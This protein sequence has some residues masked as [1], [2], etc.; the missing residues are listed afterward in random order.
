MPVNQA[1]LLL[2]H[3]S[4][5]PVARAEY[6]NV[7][8]EVSLRLPGHR[9]EF[10]VLEFPGDD[11]KSIADGV[12][13]CV[14]AGAER[15]IALPYFLFVAGHVGED[16]PG[17]LAAAAAGYPELTLAYQPPLGVDPAVVEVLADRVNGVLPQPPADDGAAVVL[18][19]A[20]TSDPLANADL[21]RAARLLWERRRSEPVEVAFVSLTEPRLD[22]VVR[23][24][25]VLGAR[26]LVVV[27]Y[28]LNTGVLSRR[29]ETQLADCRQQYQPLETTLTPEMGLHPRL[30]DLLAERARAALAAPRT[31]LALPPCSGGGAWACWLSPSNQ[32][33]EA[34]LGV[35]TNQ[36]I[37]YDLHNRRP[38]S[39][40]G[41]R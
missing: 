30:L 11:L 17:E 38:G 4:R 7:V 14:E 16:L 35:T 39:S 23:R 9:V 28:F 25:I 8:R 22:E 20:G 18:V 32:E 36:A 13:A 21:Y 26:R 27:P 2:A 10:S 15:V 31:G 37:A 40:G 12:R 19:G 3:G 34:P 5:N 6:G 1:V 29:I 33:P 24:C 41:T